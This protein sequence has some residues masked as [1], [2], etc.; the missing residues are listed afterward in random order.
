MSNLYKTYGGLS[1]HIE[2]LG[3]PMSN[4]CKTCGGLSSHI[5]NLRGPMSDL[6]MIHGRPQKTHGRPQSDSFETVQI[7]NGRSIKE[8][9][10]RELS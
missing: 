6:Y 1:N 7:F 4:L 8:P 2:N 10:R 9:L 5:E 3:R